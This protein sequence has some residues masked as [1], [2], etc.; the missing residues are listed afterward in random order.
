MSY[1]DTTLPRFSRLA[2]LQ[3]TYNFT[4]TCPLCHLPSSIPG[5]SDTNPDPRESVWCPKRCGG[6][7]ALPLVSSG[8]LCPLWG[9][10]FLLRQN[11]QI[12]QIP[13]P[14]NVRNVGQ[15]F[16]LRMWKPF[17]KRSKSAR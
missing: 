8:A 9:G 5:K 10:P 11:C 17:R 15:P 3:E 7:C 16:L 12:Q 4:C 6:T 1:V 13:L 14:Q 2:A